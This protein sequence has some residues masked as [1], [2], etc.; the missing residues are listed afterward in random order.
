[1]MVMAIEIVMAVIMAIGMVVVM[2]MEIGNVN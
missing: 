2:K 1:M